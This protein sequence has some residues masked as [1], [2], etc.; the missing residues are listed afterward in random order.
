MGLTRCY[1][2]EVFLH[3][4]VNIV[5]LHDAAA[6]AS[7]TCMHHAVISTGSE[8]RGCVILPVVG[9]WAGEDSAGED[10]RLHDDGICRYTMVPRT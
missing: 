9:L 7:S 3:L 5:I 6:A 1:K 8:L 4:Y 2:T 10:S